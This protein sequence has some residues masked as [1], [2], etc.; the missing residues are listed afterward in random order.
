MRVQEFLRNEGDVFD[1]AERY[2]IDAKYHPRYPN[3]CL[4]KYDQI[5][6]PFGEPIVRECRGVILDQARNWNVVSRPFDKFFNF[7]EG[8]AAPID[9]EHA[10]VQDKVDGSLMTLYHHDDAW[11]VA[12]SGTPDAGGNVNGLPTTFAQLFWETFK[13]GWPVCCGNEEERHSFLL[14]PHG[15]EDLCFMFELTTPHNRVVVQHTDSKITL[16]AVRNRRTGEYMP[17]ANWCHFYPSVTVYPMRSLDQALAALKMQSGLRYEGFVVVNPDGSRVKMKNDDYV[18]LHH[19]RDS[20]NGSPKAMLEIVRANESTEF[21]AHFP[22]W[23]ADYDRV[24]LVYEELVAELEQAYEA[25][26]Y[27]TVQ[28]EFALEAVKTR[29]SGALFSLRS[30]KV[31]SVRHH[32]A[33]I[34]IKSLMETLKLKGDADDAERIPA[35]S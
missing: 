4:L 3:L 14:P 21:L 10:M 30:G 32:L 17:Y 25:I 23:Q 9:W 6:S 28:K 35:T 26:R 13:K 2:A 16:L 7:G 8:L 15:C 12:S 20:I 1:L 33:Q 24:K 22:E 27:K 29:C 18:R 34:T 11:H 5:D 31:K 19:M